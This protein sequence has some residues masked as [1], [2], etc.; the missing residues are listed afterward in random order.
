MITRLFHLTPSLKDLKLNIEGESDPNN[1]PPKYHDTDIIWSETPHL[2]RARSHEAVRFRLH[3]FGGYTMH[4]FSVDGIGNQVHW[5]QEG[6]ECWSPIL[7]TP[8]YNAGEHSI[9]VVIVAI[10]VGPQASARDQIGV[11][12]QV[13]TAK[14]PVKIVFTPRL[15]G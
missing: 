2:V 3:A 8:Y 11:A 9:E 15:D 13:H 10:A 14:C 4:A 5:K 7:V 1:I 6:A 12:P